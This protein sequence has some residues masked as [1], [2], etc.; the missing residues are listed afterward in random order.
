MMIIAVSFALCVGWP[1]IGKANVF[2]QHN[3]FY[4]NS[5]TKSSETAE[6][7]RALHVLYYVLGETPES[8][9][10]TKPGSQMNVIEIRSTLSHNLFDDPSF[11][12]ALAGAPDAC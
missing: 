4:C 6:A 7:C 8:D 12:A 1:E 10:K 3:Q 11:F 2:E 5:N 9:A